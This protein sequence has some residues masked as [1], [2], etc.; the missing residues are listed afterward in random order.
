MALF[1]VGALLI[2]GF[3]RPGYWYLMEK[4]AAVAI[5]CGGYGAVA[6]AMVTVFVTPAA[7]SFRDPE[8]VFGW[9][10][11]GFVIAYTA[12]AILHA[13]LLPRTSVE[14]APED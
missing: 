9:S 12:A 7:T 11:L 6:V 13:R 1:L 8:A 4:F 14:P 10:L 2:R 5:F 3:L